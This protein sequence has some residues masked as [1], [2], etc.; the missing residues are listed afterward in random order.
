MYVFSTAGQIHP[1]RKTVCTTVAK[2][3]NRVAPCM[4]VSVTSCTGNV[5]T[6]YIFQHKKW[7]LVDKPPSV[8]APGKWLILQIF[9]PGGHFD[10]LIFFTFK[11][12]VK[13]YARFFYKHFLANKKNGPPISRAK[14]NKVDKIT[15]QGTWVCS[16]KILFVVSDSPWYCF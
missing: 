8:R 5:E 1:S 10:P 7:K 16:R 3:V 14:K 6:V 2:L 4:G 15:G 13:K 12:R 11:S 9:D